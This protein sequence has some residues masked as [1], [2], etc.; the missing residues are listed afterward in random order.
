MGIKNLYRQAVMVRE[1]LLE[2]ASRNGG[3]LASN[4]GV[5]ELTIALLEVFDFAEDTI[6]FDI[7]HQSHPYKILTD[8]SDRFLKLG[9]RDGLSNFPDIRE[10]NFDYYNTGHSGT[11]V[12]AALGY[13]MAFPNN[14]HI[15]LL[16]DG[17]LTSGETFEALNHAGSLRAP[18]IVVMNDNQMS[19]SPNVG[20]LSDSENVK[21]F[22]ESFGQFGGHHFLVKQR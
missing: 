12:S 9:R 17:A 3:H 4:L 5:V 10:S 22:V 19:I 14:H 7:G 18:I 11:S 15:A 1:V 21:G 6:V 8:R 20:A 2:Q 13:A 16:G